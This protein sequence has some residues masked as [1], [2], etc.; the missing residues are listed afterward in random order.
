[1]AA[2]PAP[3]L[4]IR[5]RGACKHNLKNV[6]VRIPRHSL[7]VVTGPSGSGKTSLAFDTLFAVGQRRFVESL[8]TYARRFLGRIDRGEVDSVEGLSPAIAIDQKRASRSPR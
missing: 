5:V 1:M 2:E 8:S 4:D 6:S 7:T 3:D